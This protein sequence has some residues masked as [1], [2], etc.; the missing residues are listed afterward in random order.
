VKLLICAGGTGGGVYPALSVRERLSA[1][2]LWVGGVGGMEADLVKRESIPFEAIPAAGVAGVGLRALPGNLFKLG[3]GFLASRKILRRFQPDVL[4]FTGGYVAVPMALAARTPR[5]GIRRPRIL[6][7]VP[8]IEP[9]L[10]L[11]TLARFADSVAV[12]AEASRAYFASHRAVTVTGY[13]LRSRLIAWEPEKARQAL[14]LSAGLPVLLVMGG[15][16]GARTINR[17]LLAALPELLKEMQI[18]HISGQAEWP[19]VEAARTGLASEL[20]ARYHAYPY[21]HEEIGAAFTIADLVLSRAGAYALGELPFFGLPAILVPYPYAWRYQRVNA[22]YL[23]RHSAA[24]VIEN[25]DLSS[26]ILPV[27]RD[28]MR[29]ANG[30]AQMRQSMRSLSHPQA[31]E[32]IAGL[33]RQLAQD[34]LHG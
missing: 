3:Q 27:V 30:R 8:D 11:K 7:Y 10:A 16:K 24:V 25:A 6:L 29:D 13:P 18:V 28:L 20:A 5:L 31:A 14:G 21:L 32:A 34:G 19:E 9:G 12:T 33:V 22:D 1:E 4:L 17:S 2:I 23:A 26:Q 15:S